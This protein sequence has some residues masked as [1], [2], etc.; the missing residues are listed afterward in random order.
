MF[1][2]GSGFDD[3]NR[4]NDDGFNNRFEN[5]F[6]DRGFSDG[7]D[8][9]GFFVG[10]GAGEECR[11]FFPF[12]NVVFLLIRPTIKIVSLLCSYLPAQNRPYPK[13]FIAFPK[14]FL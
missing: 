8:N 12:L 2:P 9:D 3:M 10:G 7:F 6:D 11:K 14:I 5:G 4:I 1:I 13:R